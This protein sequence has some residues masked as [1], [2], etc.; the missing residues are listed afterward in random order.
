MKSELQRIVAKPDGR[1]NQADDTSPSQHLPR[2]KIGGIAPYKQERKRSD[3]MACNNDR[4]QICHQQDSCEPERHHGEMLRLSGIVFPSSRAAAAST[5]MTRVG[6]TTNAVL[7]GSMN[8][9]TRHRRNIVPE[10]ALC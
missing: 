5:I 1:E 8:R 4:G 9:K 3:A 10:A 7:F 2:Q 6:G